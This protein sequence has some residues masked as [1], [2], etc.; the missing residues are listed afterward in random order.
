[1]TSKPQAWEPGN[2]WST[3]TKRWQV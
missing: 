3:V 2:V 1:M